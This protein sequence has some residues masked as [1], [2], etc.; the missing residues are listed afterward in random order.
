MSSVAEIEQAIARL[1]EA[2]FGELTRWFDEQRNRKWDEQIE[3][4]ARNG[5]LRKAYQRLQ[6]ENQ[7]QPEVPLDKVVD[8]QQLP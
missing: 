5:N 6:S 2:E 7:G 3:Q 4:D 8:D 1:S